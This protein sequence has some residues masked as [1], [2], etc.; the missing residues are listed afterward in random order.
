MLFALQVPDGRRSP[1][2]VADRQKPPGFGRGSAG[3]Q[4]ATFGYINCGLAPPMREGAPVSLSARVEYDSKSY[5]ARYVRTV[6]TLR[7]SRLAD[8]RYLERPFR[9]RIPPSPPLFLTFFQALEPRAQRVE[10]PIE[11]P[12]RPLAAHSRLTLAIS[13]PPA[14]IDGLPIVVARHRRL[15]VITYNIL[16]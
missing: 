10:W 12:I 1:R 4:F 14:K 5:L 8:E 15:Y 6:A 9:V 7:S 2:T 16:K 11:C 13:F 3:G